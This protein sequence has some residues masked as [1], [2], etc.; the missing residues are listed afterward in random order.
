MDWFLRDDNS[1]QQG[2]SNLATK[3]FD[4]TSQYNQVHSD[5]KPHMDF[6]KYAKSSW[7]TIVKD[8]LHGTQ[9]K[10]MAE[11]S[12][13]MLKQAIKTGAGLAEGTTS[14]GISLVV[15]QLTDFVVDKA[16][17]MFKT[18]M[19]VFESFEKGMWIFVNRGKTSSLEKKRE[20]LYME[21]SLF[22]DY[23]SVMQEDESSNMYS[24]GFYIAGIPSQGK[25]I[26]YVYDTEESI[27]VSDKLVRPVN[28]SETKAKWDQD[29]G[30]TTIRELWFLREAKKDEQY[31]PFQV[32]D[33]VFHDNKLYAVKMNS[34][35]GVIIKDSKTNKLLTVDEQSL[36]AGP[37]SHWKSEKPGD[38]RSAVGTFSRGTFAYR[39]INHG[40]DHIPNASRAK[41]VLCIVSYFNGTLVEVVDVWTACFSYVR[42]EEIV[43]P[44]LIARRSMKESN[45]GYKRLQHAVIHQTSLTGLSMNKEEFETTVFAYD[46]EIPFPDVE[47][48]YTDK[49]NHVV[50]V[51]P[52]VIVTEPTTQQ[53]TELTTDGEPQGDIIHQQTSGFWWILGAVFS[54]LIFI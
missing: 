16:A 6:S 31:H 27:T 9:F 40:I 41:A 26:V 5:K 1:L 44:T 21:A 7:D 20:E 51:S 33:E 49:T 10:D 52:P 25:H 37:R 54:L 30:M 4:T 34:E 47:V 22:G 38:F 45:S 32:G 3:Y 42:P 48:L 46:Q 29:S 28:D 18:H 35:S 2:L 43:Q 15:G 36:T 23:D 50:K 17:D 13:T 53:P 8:V 14:A 11:S 12:T 24:P 39:P 19:N